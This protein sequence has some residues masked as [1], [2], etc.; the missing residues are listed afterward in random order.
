MMWLISYLGA[1]WIEASWQNCG[2][3][4]GRELG[5]IY[6]FAESFN[7]EPGMRHFLKNKTN[8]YNVLSE[9]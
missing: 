9:I 1:V 3:S 8:M 4:E 7:V 6:L 5:L 2:P